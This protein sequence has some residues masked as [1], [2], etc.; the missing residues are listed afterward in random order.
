MEKR[1]P[2]PMMRT[3]LLVMLPA[4]CGGYDPPEQAEPGETVTAVPGDTTKVRGADQP[5]P[6]FDND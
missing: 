4:G 3:V 1:L 6:Q 2:P 5:G